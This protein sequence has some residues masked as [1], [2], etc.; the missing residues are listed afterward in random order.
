MQHMPGCDGTG[1]PA[2]A[3]PR[4]VS[5]RLTPPHVRLCPSS[6]RHSLSAFAAAPPRPEP[7]CA[8]GCRRGCTLVMRDAVV[9]QCACVHAIISGSNG[10]AAKRI[11]LNFEVF[12]LIGGTQL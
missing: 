6:T 8:T 10:L 3:L 2:A 4:K 1:G 5:R 11:I 9:C 12:F 7:N